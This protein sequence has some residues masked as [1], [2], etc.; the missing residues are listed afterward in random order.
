MADTP[1]KPI[2]SLNDAIC[3]A[4]DHWQMTNRPLKWIEIVSTLDDL[5]FRLVE[6]VLKNHERLTGKREL[7]PLPPT[8][9]PPTEPA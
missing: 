5:R 1:T 8:P 3:H 2:K 4:V 9:K 7:P 6:H